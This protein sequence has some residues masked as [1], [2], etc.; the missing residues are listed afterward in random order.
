M[1]EIVLQIQKHFPLL[2]VTQDKCEDRTPT[3]TTIRDYYFTN[4]KNERAVCNW[5]YFQPGCS[6]L[7]QDLFADLKCTIF[8]KIYSTFLYICDSYTVAEL[9]K[10]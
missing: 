5:L 10:F 7:P 8:T 9:Y 4:F 2:K 1:E 3:M 6:L